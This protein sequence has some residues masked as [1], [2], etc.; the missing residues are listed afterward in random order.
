MAQRLQRERVER[1]LAER[2]GEAGAEARQHVQAVLVDRVQERAVGAA[3]AARQARRDARDGR[4]VTG[5][6]ERL[7][8][9]VEQLLQAGL[10]AG[11]GAREGQRGLRG[12]VPQQLALGLAERLRPGAQD[13]EHAHRACRPADRQRQCGR[14]A[15]VLQAACHGG[16]QRR[17]EIGLAAAHRLLEPAVEQGARPRQLGLERRG[18]DVHGARDEHSARAVQNAH[19]HGIGACKLGRD[20]REQRERAGIVA[21]ARRRGGLVERRELRGET[22][23]ADGRMRGLERAARDLGDAVCEREILRGERLAGVAAAEHDGDAGAIR[24]PQ[25]ERENGRGPSVALERDVGRV[26]RDRGALVRER[27][28]GEAAVGAQVPA[29]HPARA[30]PRARGDHQSP[31]RLADG[32]RGPVARE[33]LGGR[34]A[35]RIEHAI[36]IERNPGEQAGRRAHAV[37]DRRSPP[38]RSA[39]RRV[40]LGGGGGA[41]ALEHPARSAEQRLRGLGR[42]AGDLRAE[43]DE[44]PLQRAHEGDEAEAALDAAGDLPLQHERRERRAVRIAQAALQ[45]LQR[46]LAARAHARERDALGSEHLV[47]HERAPLEQRR[48]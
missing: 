32:D 30:A 20:A 28:R 22:A 10:D 19:Q 31:V 3:G 11:S 13:L 46:L 45:R 7:A 26:A 18:V 27:A 41:D 40:E 15:A 16:L 17:V 2:I 29:L 14:N 39:V 37:G 44:R 8:R 1:A 48:A 6:R 35:D 23:R 42:R 34:A 25:R 47:R 24:V 4:A 12:H 5:R 21:L 36:E 33:S 38:Q 43:L 9:D